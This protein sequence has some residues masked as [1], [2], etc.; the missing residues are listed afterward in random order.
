[1]ERSFAPE[2]SVTLGLDRSSA[3]PLYRQ[4]YRGLREGILAGTLPAGS[5]LPSVRVL[6]RELKV[7][8]NT[9]EG[10]LAQLSAEGYLEARVGS[11]TYVAVALPDDTLRAGR[12]RGTARGRVSPG[13]GSPGGCEGLSRRG[14][15]LA[16][17][18]V[19]ASGRRRATA[20]RPFRPAVPAV[21]EFPLKVWRGLAGEFWR[22]PP[23]GSLG[24]GEP[25]GYRPLRMAI[26]EHLRAYRAVRC[27]WER[28]IVVSGSQQALDLCARLLLDEGDEAWIEDPCYLG[29]R[30]ALSAN[31]ARLVPV[32]VDGEGLDV[33]SGERASPDARLACVTP[34]HQYPTGATMSLSRRLALLGWASRSGAWV[35][36]DDYDGEFRYSGRPLSS[37]QG[38]DNEGRV[39]YV[40]TFSKVLSPALR[41]GYVVVPPGL[42]NAFEGA[43]ALAD[44]HP[45]VPEQAILAEFVAEGHFARHLRRMRR[46]YAERQQALVDAAKGELAGLLE[47]RP[48]GAGLHLVGRLPDGADDAEVSVRLAAGGV[49]A[50]PLSAHRF[51][52]SGTPGLVLGYAAFDETVIR[53]GVG[54][55]AGTLQEAAS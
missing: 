45:P 54:R 13:G 3:A 15:T 5:R 32:P 21:D 27:S 31:G 43:R 25:A 51:S 38:L 50:P 35:L 41:M 11:G 37:L 23:R 52:S 40:G 17:T 24:Y 8:R 49:E 2:A 19:S 6:M 28:V 34:S 20:P 44:R 14:A 22:R 39:I 10:A 29:A 16:G 53:D 4:L 7:S 33:A 1:M 12:A 48:S 42:V 9:V 26:A 46:L 18:P 30:G 47:V 36:E 55:M